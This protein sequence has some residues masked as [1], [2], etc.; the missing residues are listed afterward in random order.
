[1]NRTVIGL[2]VAVILAAVLHVF[3]GPAVW[4]PL[5]IAS[6]LTPLL[7]ALMLFGRYRFSITAAVVAGITIDLISPLPFGVTSLPLIIGLTLVYVLSQRSVT[8][9]SLIAF[10]I[11]LG[12]GL[13][14][15][16]LLQLVF[17]VIIFDGLE[18]ASI[19]FSRSAL[20]RHGIQLIQQLI[21]CLLAYGIIRLSGRSYATLAS[22]TF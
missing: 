11:L 13:I 3:V 7:L 1:M 4:P 15:T 5:M 12:I 6:P 21:T 22:R 19:T 10:T 9:R 17:M 18:N 8:D 14:V 16:H 20:E 2:S